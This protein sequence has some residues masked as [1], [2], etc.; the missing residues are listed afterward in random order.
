MA[1]NPHV[2][3]PP[4]FKAKPF[5]GLEVHAQHG[6]HHRVVPSLVN[7]FIPGNTTDRNQHRMPV[8]HHVSVTAFMPS[9]RNA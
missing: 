1:P 9:C 3:R 4:R 7:L 5:T 6:L 2:Q 8:N